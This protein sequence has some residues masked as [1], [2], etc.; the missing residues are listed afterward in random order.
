MERRTK[1]YI[2][3]LEW[4]TLHDGGRKL[5]YVEQVRHAWSPIMLVDVLGDVHGHASREVIPCTAA[6]AGDGLGMLARHA[7]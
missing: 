4:H 3:T 1:R 2:S 5:L 7:L 6:W